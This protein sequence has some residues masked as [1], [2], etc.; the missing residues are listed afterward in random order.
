MR[1]RLSVVAI[2]AACAGSRPTPTTPKHGIEAAALP[3][4]VLDRTGH[5]IDEKT[6]W[7]RLAAQR[8]VCIGEEHPNPHHHWVQLDAVRHLA[9]RWH[10]FA[11]GMEMVQRP[12]QGVLD[13]FAAG[14]I[15]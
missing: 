8:A 12:F 2:L 6:Y 11:L 14:R 10:V 5:Q 4:H 15:S 9:P 7:D 1:A 13:D 3:L